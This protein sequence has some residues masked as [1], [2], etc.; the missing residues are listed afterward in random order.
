[1]SERMSVTGDG[2]NTQSE[3]TGKSSTRKSNSP[4][5]NGSASTSDDAKLLRTELGIHLIH[6]LQQK[7]DITLTDENVL[8]HAA[9]LVI[10]GGTYDKTELDIEYLLAALRGR[11]EAIE[12]IKYAI[13]YV[14]RG[15]PLPEDVVI[16]LG[17]TKVFTAV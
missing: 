2:S 6:Q 9:A 12:N 17:L 15:E 13:A 10:S 16:R 3:R 5:A 8:F 1:M 7:Y 11:V 4:T 14:D